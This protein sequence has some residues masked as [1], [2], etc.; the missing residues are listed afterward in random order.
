MLQSRYL[1]NYTTLIETTLNIY[2]H[3]SRGRKILCAERLKGMFKI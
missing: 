2:V 3:Y 1:P